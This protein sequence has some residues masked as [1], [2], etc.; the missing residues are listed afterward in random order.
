MS[1]AACKQIYVYILPCNQSHPG[2]ISPVEVVGSIETWI[3]QQALIWKSKLQ[4]WRILAQRADQTGLLN[5]ILFVCLTVLWVRRQIVEPVLYPL[6]FHGWCWFSC[7]SYL[8]LFPQTSEEIQDAF[9][10]GNSIKC[11]KQGNCLKL[12]IN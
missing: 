8:C 5:F 4:S 6:G 12:G 9:S 1:S 3:S 10:S 7:S 11:P 2:L